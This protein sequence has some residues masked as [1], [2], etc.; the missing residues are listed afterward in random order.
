MAKVVKEWTRIEIGYESPEVETCEA[1]PAMQG[2]LERYFLLADR[3]RWALG[4]QTEIDHAPSPSDPDDWVPVVLDAEL[5]AALANSGQG[6][7]Q[8]GALVK[9]I[10]DGRMSTRL[11]TGGAGTRCKLIGDRWINSRSY[12]L[13]QSN[14]DPWPEDRDPESARLFATVHWPCWAPPA[15]SASQVRGRSE[16]TP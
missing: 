10:S 7:V 15:L 5:N 11:P 12:E 1:Q 13:L 16:T 4:G 14:D 3:T 8:I 2:V 6:T 9:L